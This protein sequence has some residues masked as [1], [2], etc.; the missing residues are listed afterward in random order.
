MK[1]HLTDN[2]EISTG[3][4][5][6][7]NPL[8]KVDIYLQYP[9]IKDLIKSSPKERR[10]AIGL[11]LQNSYQQLKE[12]LPELKLKRIG[13]KN[14]PSGMTTVLNYQEL[15]E[16]AKLES[17]SAISI[18]NIKGYEEKKNKPKKEYFSVKVRIAIQ[19]EGKKKGSQDYENRIVI[20]KAKS[21]EKA[22]KKVIKGLEKEEPYLNP[23][24]HLVKWKFE[25]ILDCYKTCIE[26]KSEFD[27]K[28][29]VEIFSQIKKR[30]L[31]K[32][33][34]FEEQWTGKNK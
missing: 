19:I 30:K 27:L 4:L 33:L 13:D 17:I 23:Y 11:E 24:G 8:I 18:I 26:D 1:L 9:E 12:M 5:E 15:L 14:R 28:Y 34:V 16:V 6:T 20:V 3:D 21:F 25:K 22:V 31:T 2:F 32:E 29:G 10:K 7:L